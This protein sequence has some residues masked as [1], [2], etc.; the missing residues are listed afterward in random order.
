MCFKL[1]RR[2]LNTCWTVLLV[3]LLAACASGSGSTSASAPVASSSAPAAPSAGSSAA[4]A[5]SAAA[6][7]AAPAAAA[8]STATPVPLPGKVTIA[9]SSVSGDFLP[10]WVTMETGLFAKYGLDADVT[11]VASGTTA[12]QSLVAG[13]VQ[14]VL[15][16]APESA[17]ALA[18]GAPVR[19]VTA[20]SQGI[21]ALFMVD[22]NITSPEQ[23][24]DKPLGISRFGGQPHVAARL[25]LKKWGLDPDTTVQYVQLGGVA[26]ILAAMQQG[27]V[28]GGVFSP[29]TNVRAQKLGFRVLGDLAQMDVGYQTDTLTALQPWIEQNPEALR[30]VERAVIE[31]M[32]TTLEDD[33]TALA[34]LSKYTHIDEPDVLMETLTY[35]RTVFKRVPY[36][37]M[38]A[39][40]NHL[41]EVAATDPRARGLTADQLADTSA[42]AEIERQG[43]IKQLY[44]E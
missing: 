4:A 37:S 24:R 13:D 8:A 21:A 42:L 29:P 23:L 6:T 41:D 36:P 35:L 1:M 2:R 3:A 28:V 10:L 31:G 27:A 39:L 25:A 12:M 19:I 30:R 34:A 17:A 22:P 11:Y 43:F 20:W 15:S 38:A 40:Q 9:Y 18:G 33:A 16:S 5:S 26:E 32:K 7:G 14:F 44:G